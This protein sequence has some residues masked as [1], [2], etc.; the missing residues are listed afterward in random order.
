MKCDRAILTALCVALTPAAQGAPACTAERGWAPVIE[1][2]TSQGCSSCPPADA[3]LASLASAAAAQQ[4]LPL[5]FHVDYWDGLGWRDPHARPEH[6]ARQRALARAE[7]SG[8]VYTPQVRLAGDDFRRWSNPAALREALN[9]Q[10]RPAPGRVRLSS[11]LRG[12]SIVLAAESVLAADAAGFI[13]VYERN[14]GSHV[15]A[16]ENAGRRLAHDFVVRRWIGPFA[17]DRQGRW[18]LNHAIAL[19]PVWKRADLGVALVQADASSGASRQGAG[20][21][22]CPSP[23]GD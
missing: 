1:L 2:Y 4:L 19:D 5:A 13:A 18:T 20:F 8:V 3:W 17:P 23:T 21:P 14:L 15:A 22:L 6:S 10:P 11:E 7:G 9:H 12:Q 16:G